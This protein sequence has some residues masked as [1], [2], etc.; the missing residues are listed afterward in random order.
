LDTKIDF[1]RTAIENL[2]TQ[3]INKIDEL[4]QERLA[5]PANTKSKQELYTEV[6]TEL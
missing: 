5:N 6:A 2:N 4:V 1:E 3:H